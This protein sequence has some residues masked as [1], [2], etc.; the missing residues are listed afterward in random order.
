MLNLLFPKI[1]V[2]C[3]ELLVKGEDLLCVRC[4]HSLPMAAYHRI[5]SEMLKDRFYGRFSVANATA[6]IQFQKRGL[7]QELLHSLKYRGRA[8]ISSFFGKWLGAELAEIESYSKVEMVIPVPLHKQKLKQRG[9]NQVEGF[10]KELALALEIPYRDNILIKISKTGS[11]VFKTR[12]LRFAAEEEF[13]IQNLKEIEN[14]HIL[15]VDDIITTGATLEK[16][17]LQLLKAENVTLSIA[18]IAVT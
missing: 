13:S 3:K 2:G 10:G 1:C 16:C 11:Q 5:G 8:E 14:K 17:A 9:F 4:I 7:T 6:L 15:L 18:T 12:I